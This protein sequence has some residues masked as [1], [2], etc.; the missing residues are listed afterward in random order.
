MESVAC[1][2]WQC[3]QAVAI[4][5]EPARGQL[6]LVIHMTQGIAFIQSLCLLS[7]SWGITIS[8]QGLAPHAQVCCLCHRLLVVSY[9][10][11]YTRAIS[12]KRPASYLGCEWAQ[13]TLLSRFW[14]LFTRIP[15]H[16]DLAGSFGVLSALRSGPHF[17]RKARLHW[18]SPQHSGLGLRPCVAGMTRICIARQLGEESHEKPPPEEPPA[19]GAICLL[20]TPV[21]GEEIGG[22]K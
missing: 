3:A 14:F 13:L 16:S 10:Q 11:G 17:A 12:A 2:T 20:T 9:A 6:E 5:V 18:A 1:R 8:G 7:C 4:Q 21:F 15:R 19:G 22:L